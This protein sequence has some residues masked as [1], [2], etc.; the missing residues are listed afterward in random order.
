MI[1]EFPSRPPP[2]PF[3]TIVC[4]FRDKVTL[5]SPGQCATHYADQAIEPVAIFLPLPPERWGYRYMPPHLV[6]LCIWV[7]HMTL[8]QRGGPLLFSMH[9]NQMEISPGSFHADLL[10][11]LTTGPS[12]SVPG[13]ATSHSGMFLCQC[14]LWWSGQGGHCKTP[15]CK[16]KEVQE[17]EIVKPLIRATSVSS[18]AGS[19]WTY[20]GLGFSYAAEWEG[21][22]CRAQVYTEAKMQDRW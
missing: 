2:F 16:A 21:L 22:A 15:I 18:V 6:V 12:A 3:L 7:F 10:V 1:T 8:I 9:R 13:H 19:Q 4:S 5:C 14:Q 20:C 17:Q 11:W